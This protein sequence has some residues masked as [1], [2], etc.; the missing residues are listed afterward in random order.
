MESNTAEAAAAAQTRPVLRLF[1]AALAAIM[2]IRLILLGAYPL[3]D[4][5]EARYALIGRLMYETGDWI[6]PYVQ[7]GQPFWAK[8]PLSFWG[9][10]AAYALF[11]VH[12]FSARLPSYM[13]FVAVSWF[14]FAL[15]RDHR[16]RL[17]ALLATLIFTSCMLA[18]YLGGAVMTDPALML[19]I[20]ITMAAFWNCMRRPSRLWGY[21]FFVGLAVSL[22][23]NGKVGV[24][25]PGLAIG[26]WVAWHRKWG[27]TWRNLPWC[28]GTL[29][30]ILLAVPWYLLA[31]WRTPGFLHYFIIG[32]HFERFLVKD[33]P[34]DLYG[35]PRTHFQGMIW[36]FALAA[37]LPWSA[38]VAVAAFRRR[39]HG[40]LFGREWIRDE[41]L[42]YMA[43]W[44]L[45]PLVFFTLA[46]AVLITYVA[47]SM[48]PFALLAA[49]ILRRLKLDASAWP[50]AVSLLVPAAFVTM[51][52]ATNLDAGSDL[53]P[54]QQRIV[55][56][57]AQR[58]PD[59]DLVYFPNVPFSAEFYSKGTAKAARTVQQLQAWLDRGPARFAISRRAFAALP[60]AL[61]ARF[62][63]IVEA[64]GTFLLRAQPGALK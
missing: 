57:H 21:L 3:F 9:T 11:G 23:D 17:F 40:G 15:A 53:I 39:P 36:L 64:N 8:P 19:G 61:Q 37:A 20:T 14:V 24:V 52:L 48:P 63:T 29:L 4:N 30:T 6:T 28:T 7:I 49:H 46:H 50:A 31:E 1:A 59:T 18:N 45:A 42:S 2:A 55:S 44:M 33:W 35:A 5:T 56:A 58:S 32:E 22:L 12:E 25:L 16:D 38:V 26:A 27:D 34:G 47:A 60:K 62:H 43:F 54:S 51:A 10:A 13:I 41:W